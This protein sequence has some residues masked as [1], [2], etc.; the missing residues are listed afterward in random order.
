M[1]YRIETGSVFL[2]TEYLNY[3]FSFLGILKIGAVAQPLFS[4]FGDESLYVE[5]EDAQTRAIITQSKYLPK[6]RRIRDKLPFLEYIIVLDHTKTKN[7]ENKE[8]AF[9]LEEIPAVEK[10]EIFP[11]KSES[12]SVFTLYIWNHRATKGV[13]HVHYSLISQYLTT[14][15]VLD[16][17]DDDIYWCTARSGG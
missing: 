15:W 2:W 6:I 17:Q 1:D 3:T 11:T 7:L 14:K 12:P 16:L 4:A 8:Y 10:M 13:Q 5:L 9:Y